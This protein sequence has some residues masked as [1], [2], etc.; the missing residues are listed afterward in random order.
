MKLRI[1]S[2]LLIILS[3]MS[4]IP[5]RNRGG[6]VAEPVAE[7]RD[8]VYPLGFCTDSF[9]VV[10]GTIK[11]GDNFTAWLTRLG[12]SAQQAHA[13]AGASDTV[14]DVRKLRAGNAYKAY[15]RDS[16]AL[17][18]VVYSNSQV[19][20]TIFSLRDSIPVWTYERPVEIV[21][22]T[23]DVTIN[24]SLWNDMIAAGA[25][26]DL[27]VNIADIYA[28]TVDFFGLQKGDRFRIL[29]SERMC[30]GESVG[31]EKV[32]Y[33]EFH[34]GDTCLP[35]VYF[36]QGDGGNTY[37]N[38][39]GESMRKAFLKAPLKFTRISS[40]YSLHR[41]H[42][43]H[44]TVRAHTG[45]DYA[46]PTGTPVRSIGDGTVL[47]AGWGKG[48]AG[49]MVKIR[50]NSVYTTAYLHLSKMAVKAGQRVSQGQ[51]IG[52]VGMTGTATGPHLD[53]RV[54]RNGS[55]INPLKLESPPS[56]PIREENL[57]ALDSVLVQMRDII[58]R[59]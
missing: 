3:A 13:L 50:H 59:I 33:A 49:N 10:P 58:N 32:S 36:D 34:R 1:G 6:A 21:T 4:C 53:F 40:G 45:V 37:W 30:E 54:W 38:E 25:S 18:Y 29:Y 39:K 27:I 47:S 14:F 23:A 55:P 11:S 8:T 17:Q 19:K 22:K 48:G 51:V 7:V 12:A 57:S 28:W 56:E 16:S 35:A 41:L 46:A 52:Y 2:I 15:Y 44:G 26:P 31:I 24:S 42:P 43:V 9:T 20:E 5:G